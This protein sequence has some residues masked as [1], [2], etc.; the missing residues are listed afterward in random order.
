M[1]V[2][3]EL[4][5]CLKTL[6]GLPKA[7]LNVVGEPTRYMCVGDLYN[8]TKPFSWP[9]LYAAYILAATKQAIWYFCDISRRPIRSLPTPSQ[10][11]QNE[12]IAG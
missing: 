5:Y 4:A 1:A 10:K 11:G 3:G 2:P 6:I 7:V 8:Y 9:L 12:C